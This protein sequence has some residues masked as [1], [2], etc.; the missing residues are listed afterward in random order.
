MLLKAVTQEINAWAFLSIWMVWSRL[1]M[2]S[3]TALMSLKWRV[4]TFLCL[5]RYRLF[6]YKPALK[7]RSTDYRYVHTR[8]V[9]LCI[10]PTQLIRS[11]LHRG[12]SDNRYEHSQKTSWYVYP[13]LICLLLKVTCYQKSKYLYT[14]S[15]SCAFVKRSREKYH[16]VKCQ[17]YNK[18]RQA[19]S[20]SKHVM[21][22]CSDLS[23][24]EWCMSF[25]S[26]KNV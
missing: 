16:E 11:F 2:C 6:W 4:G 23:F 19:S 3:N 18:L 9:L 14:F 10:I 7:Y 15:R 21:I 12:N 25:S 13:L 24:F 20:H 22:Y 8:S 5:G 17:S 26:N 1:P